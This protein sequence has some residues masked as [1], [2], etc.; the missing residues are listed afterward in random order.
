MEITKAVSGEAQVRSRLRLG[1]LW[2]GVCKARIYWI[3]M[4]LP[5]QAAVKEPGKHQV[6]V[7]KTGASTKIDFWA[8]DMQPDPDIT[9]QVKIALTKDPLTGK[10]TGMQA[11]ELSWSGD[12]PPEERAYD[13]STPNNLPPGSSSLHVLPLS[14]IAE[15]MKFAQRATEA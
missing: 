3:D 9:T 14:K 12:G 10:M 4:D 13:S 6:K 8:E 5:V 15:Y 1:E 2:K 11:I 7:S